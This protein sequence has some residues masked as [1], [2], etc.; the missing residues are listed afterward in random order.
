MKEKFSFTWVDQTNGIQGIYGL[1][2]ENSELQPMS[3]L[4]MKNKG[5]TKEKVEEWV[6]KNPEFSQ[7]G[8]LPPTEP[9]I[10]EPEPPKPLCFLI[11]TNKVTKNSPTAKPNED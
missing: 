2:D 11:N 8:E 9:P 4:F 1:L 5:W 7:T 3:L 6:G 10:P